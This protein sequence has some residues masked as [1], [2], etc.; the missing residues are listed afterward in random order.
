MNKKLVLILVLIV[1]IVSL[2]SSLYFFGSNDSGE[3]FSIKLLGKNSCNNLDSQEKNICLL[4]L[5]KQEGDPSY[6]GDIKDH[7]MYYACKDKIW[8]GEDCVYENLIGEGDDCYFSLSLEN[9]SMSSCNRI[10]NIKI[11]EECRNKIFQIALIE[12][13]LSICDNQDSKIEMIDLILEDNCKYNAK[14]KTQFD[15]FLVNESQDKCLYSLAINTTNKEICNQ[16]SGKNL[17]D[18]CERYFFTNH[19]VLDFCSEFE[20]NTFIKCISNFAINFNR[21]SLCSNIKE[22]I[23]KESCIDSVSKQNNI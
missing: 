7:N 2:G 18:L 8:E 23:F 19:K 13:D 5:A 14:I 10:N 20:F 22:N 3:S 12:K 1:F 4:K 11:L 21:P 16:I 15:S 9:K 6:C 17:F